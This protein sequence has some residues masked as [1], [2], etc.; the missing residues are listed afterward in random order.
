[1]SA[2]PF[3]IYKLRSGKFRAVLSRGGQRFRMH[4]TNVA[5]LQQQLKELNDKLDSE[6]I[7]KTVVQKTA[8]YQSNIPGVRYC[9][10]KKK[11]RG[12]CLDRLNGKKIYT[13][14]FTD[15]IKCAEAL[16]RL[17]DAEKL[18]FQTEID[19]RI[20]EDPLVRDL[21][22]T[23]GDI[24]D[25]LPGKVYCCVS[26]NNGY[27]PIRVVVSGQTQKGYRKACENCTQHARVERDGTTRFCRLHGGGFRCLGYKSEECP[28]SISIDRG[29]KD[30]YSGHCVRCF[31]AQFPNEERAK[32][33][34]GYI[35]AK[36][37]AV[38]KFLETAFPDYSWTFD[39]VYNVSTGRTRMIGRFR[40]DARTRI[41]D[42]VL[43]VEVDE[44]SHRGYMCS[45]E[46]EREESFVRQAAPLTVIIIRLNPDKYIDFD[47]KTHPSCFHRSDKESIISVNPR[48]QK[49]WDNRLNEL[50]NTIK[51][52]LNPE[53]VLPPKQEDRPCLM[54]ELFYD[55][56][57]DHPEAER[58]KA[59]KEKKKAIGKR[60]R[61][62]ADITK[63][64][65]D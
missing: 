10:D 29:K 52:V 21:E 3:G 54:I 55:N 2:L 15:E 11:W 59:E 35:H 43:I 47:G 12:E 57:S 64:A 62:L 30:I 51:N 49:Q 23:P 42:R 38:T 4:G 53:S 46:R 56:I 9:T 22:M 14:F 61:E 28:Y 17:R 20:D 19:K 6:N 25:A 24:Q 1:M 34:K 39:K 31:C 13:T 26:G 33:A 65:E 37:Q 58:I 44:D 36:E 60:K 5:V 40:P 63:E 16:Q 50:K 45:K 32:T 48:Q 7:P 41:A 8:E 27:K 18:A